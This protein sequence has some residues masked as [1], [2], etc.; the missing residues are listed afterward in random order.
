MGFGGSFG[1]CFV[2]GS[3]C[4]NQQCCFVMILA[5]DGGS[6]GFGVWYLV[7]LASSKFVRFMGCAPVWRKKE[8][9]WVGGTCLGSFSGGVLPEKEENERGFWVAG[10]WPESGGGGGG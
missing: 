4:C 8:N 9:G 3:S 10:D 1:C 7:G 2:S 6:D 5:G